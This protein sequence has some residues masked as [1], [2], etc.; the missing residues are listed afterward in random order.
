[1]NH[2]KKIISNYNF[3]IFKTLGIYNYIKFLFYS[4]LYFPK[5]LYSKN[6]TPLC[7]IF[8]KLVINYKNEKFIIDIKKIDKEINETNTFGLIREI[9]V[10]NIHLKFFEID[11]LINKNCI[12]LGANAGI[13]SLL[14]GKI[15]KKVVSIELQKKYKPVFENL[16]KE[17]NLNNIHLL[18]GYV[19]DVADTQY[20]KVDEINKM[21][22]ENQR[23]DIN[24]LVEKY[25]GNRLDLLK[26]NIEG[27]EFKLFE[28][29]DFSK[30]ESIS[31]E[32]HH[33]AGDVSIIKERLIKHN[34]EIIT[35]DLDLE[36]T[37][38]NNKINH[39]FARK[40]ESSVKFIPN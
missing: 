1:V 7:G 32:V 40:K 10:R 28:E 16:M 20:L 18:F 22:E 19:G 6:L 17:N 29:L 9:F 35:C 11:S 31:M 34:Y 13:F 33:H 21:K 14:A 37:S 5:I 15:F 36:K 25:F 30:I 26:M 39:I 27:G 38:I 3:N 23:I 4:I 2:T 8:D 24:L 12:D